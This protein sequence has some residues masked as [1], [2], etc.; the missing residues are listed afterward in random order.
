[1]KFTNA[2]VLAAVSSAAIAQAQVAQAQDVPAAVG[3]DAGDEIVVT[4]SRAG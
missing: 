2:L 3:P 4:G 1:M